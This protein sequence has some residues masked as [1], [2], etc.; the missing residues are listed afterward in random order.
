MFVRINDFHSS[1]TVLDVPAHLVKGGVITAGNNY[2]IS[3][4]KIGSRRGSNA[5][6][7][8][9]SIVPYWL[10]SGL[11][12]AQ[13]YWLYAGLSKIYLLAGGAHT[14]VTRQTA[15]VDVDYAATAA[16]PWTGG[17]FNG[18]SVLN[19]ENDIPQMFTNISGKCADMTNWPAALRCKSLRPFKN[20][21]VAANVTE[22]GT[23]YPQLLRWSHPADPGAV[24]SS[25]DY[26]DTTKDAGRK[27]FAET[28][29]IL[30]DSLA[31][32]D[33]HLV[34]KNDSTYYMQYVGA[35]Y[36]FSIQPVSLTSGL[37]AANCVVNVPGGQVA[38]TYDDVVFVTP[39]GVKSIA[40]KRVRRAIFNELNFSQASNAFVAVNYALSEV[41]VCIPA[42]S[43]LA[44]RAYIYNWQDDKWTL[45]NLPELTALKQGYDVSATETWD[46]VTGTWD[47]DSV[48]W[49]SYDFSGAQFLGVSPSVAGKLLVMES[50]NLEGGAPIAVSLQ[51]DSID[52]FDGLQV[53]PERMK[54][55]N[56]IRPHFTPESAG[57]VVN[58]EIGTRN[59]LSEAISWSAPKPFTVG[60]SRDLFVR[61]QGRY[62]SWRIASACN[63]QW[64]LDS[65]DIDCE[66]GG[67][68]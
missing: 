36:I 23:E 3:D 4:G 14:N 37:L 17:G 54:L 51:H 41:W 57:A 50:G 47:S 22:S 7:G 42:T 60:T 53:S 2:R 61:K 12:E 52:L 28:P 68:Y 1:D 66:I 64:E 63:V 58:F 56:R 48:P 10:L 20:F 43:T 30:V 33:V 38:L 65:M 49:G 29:G 44:N 34:Y 6:Y 27:A 31:A 21:L 15:G 55:V 9:P 16:T 40:S 25:W 59:G 45:R 46:T 19:N 32:Q 35:P 8:A 18:I 13:P 39:R 5:I 62:I 67:V 24:P 26:T 11:F